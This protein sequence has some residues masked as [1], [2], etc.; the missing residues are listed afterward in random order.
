MKKLLITVSALAIISSLAAC[1]DMRVTEPMTTS[2]P[3]ITAN[4][5]DGMVYD[6]DGIITDKDSG[7][8]S[9]KN[10]NTTTGTDNT[11]GNSAAANSGT[12]N[13]GRKIGTVDTGRAADD[14][15]K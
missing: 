13:T 5:N 14:Y 6:R 2:V 4:P 9:M 10:N 15:D 7:T 12:G 11:T 3:Y 8:D 1:G